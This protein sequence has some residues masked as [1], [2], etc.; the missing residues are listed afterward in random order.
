M[1][2]T[3]QTKLLNDASLAAITG[4]PTYQQAIR[5]LFNRPRHALKFFEPVF[6]APLANLLTSVDFN[7]LPDNA[8]IQKISYDAEKRS[9]RFAGIMSTDEQTKLDALSN[10]AN[11][12]NAVNSL[13]TQP[14]LI[15]PSDE[16]VWLVDADLQ[17]PLRDLEDP[18]KDHLTANLTTAV[19]KALAYLSKTTSVNAVVQ[20]S[21]VQLGLTEAVVGNLLTQ[22]AVLPGLLPE[23]LL[24][25]LT[26]TFA[27]T[28]GVVDYATHKITFDGWYW[29]NR[30][31]AMWKKWKLTLEELKQITLLI[32][33]AQLL[34]V[35][36]LPL[37]STQAIAAI[38]RVFRTSRLLR[39][40]DSL[41]DN[42]ITLLEVLEKLK[43]GSYP[44]PTNFATD[45]EKLNEDWFATDVEALIASLNLTYPADYF[46]A[47]NWERLRRAFYFLDSLNAKAIR[48]VRFAAA[49]MAFEDA[50]QLKELLRSKFG[51]ETWLILSTEI[52][53]V[54]RER[55]RDAL[56][57]YLLI[58]PKPADAPTKKWE[59]TNDLYA[60]YLLDVEMC[61]CQ[62]TS[63]LVQGSGSV[64]LFVQRCFMGLELD[65]V[66][67]KADGAN[68][69]SA[70]RWW[71]WMR[72]YRV[73]EANRK[74]F[75]WP[76]NWIEPELKKD[77]SS[78]FKDLEN[79]LLQN[80]INQD[81][82]EEAFINY[83]EKLDGV[84]QLEIAGFYQEDDGDNAIIHVFG[85][86][87]GA[88]PHLYYYR[89]YD[90]R[91]WT[92]W[93]KVDLDIQ[94]DYLIPAVVNKRLFLFWPVFTEVPDEEE[95]KQVSTPNPL[96]GA[97]IKKADN[98]GNSK[99]DA[100]QTQTILPKT[101]KR[102]HLQMAI[103]EYRQKKWTPKKITK[104]FHESHW[105][106]IEITKKHY[107]FFP[108]DGS[109]VDGRFSIEYE[110]SGLANDGKT[111]RAMLSG[112]FELSGCQGLLKQR[113][114]LWGNFEFS[115]QPE[116]ASVGFRPAF[117]K[118]VE[119]EVRSDQPAQ[120]F[121]LQSYIPNPPGYFS[122]TTVLGQTPWIFT[123]T[124]SWHLTYLDQLLFNGKLAFPDDV[125][126]SRLA[127]PVGSWSPF[128][129]ND[130]KRTFFVL[131]ALEVEDRKDTLSQV[132]SASIRYYYPDI[133]KHFR[134]LED[135]FEGQVQTWLDSWDLST[136]TPAQRQQIEQFLWQSFPEQ[137]PPPYAD[138]PY[139]D[140]QI[141]DLS[142]R[143]WMRGFHFHLALWS[144][145]LVQ[146]RQF[147]FKNYYH[148]FVCDFAK[149]VHNPLKGIP[150][151]MSRETQL[152]NT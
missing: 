61:S 32:A 109:E 116:N 66:E 33:D 131:P 80:E 60:Y 108:I 143:W 74:V 88:E 47:E 136:L 63:R 118:W 115:V 89:R 93:E 110:G 27:T 25:H 12:L 24:E 139:T 128:F 145:Q 113:S 133:K 104:D 112:A 135:N 76:E 150:A 146:S 4:I 8:L 14:E 65:D 106:D 129:Y 70:W 45:V 79:E 140:A 55:K 43:A 92:P 125:Q 81:T 22:Y 120:T 103:S 138:T 144:L 31:A 54:L 127:K 73:W 40:R 111:T 42:E 83:L 52:Q 122:S 6:T 9:L 148:P 85:R 48:V 90:Y 15:S 29:A 18:T 124:P 23:S 149:L 37:D 59:N 130:K 87:A 10:D 46:L 91:Q 96:S 147:H 68:G 78:F 64:Q 151:L 121:T 101:R 100:P 117:L 75:L 39:L 36:T 123:M 95:N 17:F 19:T 44:A 94:G 5:E 2:S 152:K 84:A 57:A 132:Q 97:T 102:L 41:P 114:Q 7:A 13:K 82:V 137:A 105:Y 107:E 71:K 134:Q 21:S 126:I 26:G 1:L 28:P 86:T 20:Q 35:A 72:K 62:L 34:D 49:A 67:V 53:D 3:Q 30:V 50:K 38:A 69:D 119:Q 142:K 58:Q 56:S 51:T 141:K 99:I 98:Q 11:Y 16:R 77:K